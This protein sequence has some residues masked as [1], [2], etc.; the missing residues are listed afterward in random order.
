[1]IIIEWTQR[2]DRLRLTLSR[3]GVFYVRWPGG[4][5]NLPHPCFSLIIHA[6]PMKI[7]MKM[8]NQLLIWFFA[9]I[10]LENG[11]FRLFLCWCQQKMVFFD[12]FT[13]CAA[14]ITKNTKYI[15]LKQMV[16]KHVSKAPN[17]VKNAL[18]SLSFEFP[19]F[20][21]ILK[22]QSPHWKLQCPSTKIS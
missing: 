22:I 10:L 3:G 4:G 19:D 15:F 6:M 1:M 14:F 8:S 21:N 18:Q 5:V 17:E 7:G 2:I 20:S 12:I 13:S 9:K 16:W 11:Y